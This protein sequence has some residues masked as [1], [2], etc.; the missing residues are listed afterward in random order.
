MS[1]L[2]QFRIFE[3]EMAHQI[4]DVGI[5]SKNSKILVSTK[6]SFVLIQILN[7]T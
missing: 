1:S 3:L 5:V 6:F 4:F 7:L 2:W